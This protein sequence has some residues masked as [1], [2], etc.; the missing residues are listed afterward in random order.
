MGPVAII[1]EAACLLSELKQILPFDWEWRNWIDLLEGHGALVP[2]QRWRVP[3][4]ALQR[5][6]D[7]HDGREPQGEAASDAAAHAVLA[8][9]EFNVAKAMWG[10]S[11]FATQH[12]H[13]LDDLTVGAHPFVEIPSKVS[14][15]P[16]TYEPVPVSRKGRDDPI[17]DDHGCVPL[18]RRWQVLVL[19]ELA[20]AGPR[21]FAD[22][23]WSSLQKQWPD[24]PAGKDEWR[25]G[26]NLTGFAEHRGAL[27]AL[28][29][30]AAYKHHAF[31]LAEAE[32]PDI[33][34][35]QGLGRG[36]DLTGEFVIR[37]ASHAALIAAEEAIACDALT[38]HEVNEEQLLAA[39]TWLG[40]RAVSRR[41]AG[42]AEAARAYGNLMREAIELLVSKGHTLAQVQG[43]MQD[44][45]K[46]VDQL[47]PV[48]LDRARATLTVW[49][50]ALARDFDAWPSSPFPAFSEVMVS[51]FIEWL[52]AAGLFV[53]HM[54]I[55]AIADYG[56]RTD[57]DAEVGVAVHISGLAAWVEHVCNE[58]IGSSFTDKGLAPKLERL[59]THQSC[60][61][62]RAAFAG[63]YVPKDTLFQDGVRLV[64]DRGASTMAEWMSRDARL[65]CLI[66]NEGLHRGLS[67]LD[68]REMHDA[69]CILL[70]TAMGVWLTKQLPNS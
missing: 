36:T 10:R 47:F 46:L 40:W 44:G 60:S 62:L 57:R 38:R 52:E 9:R 17:S 51:Q 70:R 67:S 25:L 41:N 20:L 11:G 2:V 35:F 58:A 50:S 37:D 16:R 66:R 5:L 14:W 26:A 31:M 59:W 28:S 45:Q 7:L 3:P 34:L 30:N 68:R 43:R 55:P 27:E 29:W 33:G 48:W 24:L 64:I 13:P 12:L 21:T 15:S 69:A 63:R 18:F 23:R 6:W 32:K 54:S 49:V 8:L 4:A 42:R 53:A 61:A 1:R 22:L 19:V 56:Q 65:A 39:A